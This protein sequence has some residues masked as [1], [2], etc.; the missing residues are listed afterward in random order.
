MRVNIVHH[1]DGHIIPRMARWLADEFG[2][3][4][5]GRS[6]DDVDLNYYMPYTAISLANP[7]RLK[8]KTAAWFTHHELG[9]LSKEREW[10]AATNAVDF[11]TVTAPIY[12]AYNY[13]RHDRSLPMHIIQAGIDRELFDYEPHTKYHEIGLSGI[14]QW[15][16]GPELVEALYEHG[17]DIVASGKHWPIPTDRVNYYAMEQLP[18]FYRGLHV[19]V[20]T[21]LIEGIP[22]PPLEALACGTKIVIPRGV[23]L[24]DN[25][26]EEPGVRRYTA[27]D[28]AELLNAVDRALEDG[29]DPEYLR[30]LTQPYSKRAWAE[31]HLEIF[32]RALRCLN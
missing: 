25:F 15:R 27:G 20:C 28:A 31:S 4:E 32:D 21:S 5:G 30:S 29:V 18:G 17:Y 19:F 9:N 2:W 7:N 11:G 1:D 16:K 22:A 26:Q 6:R 23:G 8:T 13:N 14:C 12:Q 24:L 3:S 10:F